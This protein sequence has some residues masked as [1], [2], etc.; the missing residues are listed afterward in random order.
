MTHFC[1][2]TLADSLKKSSIEQA[3]EL[4]FISNRK[5]NSREQLFM[6]FSRS[7]PSRLPRPRELVPLRL[8]DAWRVC[9]A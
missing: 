7:T 5:P 3:S 8:L 9:S 6:M 2:D 1:V 4:R